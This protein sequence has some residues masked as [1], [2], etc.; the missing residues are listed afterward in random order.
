M[1]KIPSKRLIRLIRLTRRLSLHIYVSVFWLQCRIRLTQDCQNNS[2][3]KIYKHHPH[4]E[5]GTYWGKFCCPVW[6][7]RQS[8]RC[9]RHQPTLQNYLLSC[10]PL[11][12]LPPHKQY[13]IKINVPNPID[14]PIK[15][16]IVIMS[17][18]IFLN[19]LFRQHQP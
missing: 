14:C 10:R 8:Q 16:P 2:S 3:C 13:M 12:H 19:A 7:H 17:P 1:C 4:M 18:R 5:T 11:V 9:S 15:Y 6:W